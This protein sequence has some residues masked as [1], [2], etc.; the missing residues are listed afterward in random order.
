MK[1]TSPRTKRL[2]LLS[3]TLATL[4]LQA[5]RW[6]DSLYKRYVGDRGYIEPCKGM[7][8]IDAT[9]SKENCNGDGLQWI[10]PS[11]VIDG[12]V[13]GGIANESD[14]HGT[15]NP[16]KCKYT[17]K[18]TCPQEHWAEFK[19]YDLGT[20][21]YLMIEKDN[22]YCGTYNDLMSTADDNEDN[23]RK[24]NL[25]ET[26]I[27]QIIEDIDY[28][29]CNTDTSCRTME[30]KNENVA[31][32]TNCSNNEIRCNEDC[33]DIKSSRNNC[34]TCG[35]VCY[36]G[37]LCSDGICTP[38]VQ[39]RQCDSTNKNIYSCYQI[40]GSD[41]LISADDYANDHS[42]PSNDYVITNPDD[43][44]CIS[45]FDETTCGAT[46]CNQESFTP[47]ADGYICIK[48]DDNNYICKCP[49]GTIEITDPVKGNQ[50][51][52]PNDDEHCGASQS[53]PNGENCNTAGEHRKCNGIKCVC[54][55]GWVECNGR[56]IDPLNDNVYCG[57]DAL[58]TQ[59]DECNSQQTCQRGVCVCNDER[60]INCD[61]V[62]ID[63]KNSKPHCGSSGL[64]KSDDRNSKN[65]KGIDCGSAKCIVDDSGPKCECSDEDFYFDTINKECVSK[66]SSE[67]CGDDFIDCRAKYH[68]NAK[69]NSK[70]VCV[71]PEPFVRLDDDKYI[72]KYIEKQTKEGIAASSSLCVDI[73]FD[74]RFCGENL[75]TCN[76]NQM[77]SGGKCKNID[78]TVCKSDGSGKTMLCDNRCINLDENN[79]SNCNKC[80]E[81]W[82]STELLVKTAGCNTQIGKGLNNCAQCL[83]NDN[84]LKGSKCN[85]MYSV[86]KDNKCLCA[87]GETE[88]TVKD[89]DG[90]NL[91][92]DMSKINLE[93]CSGIDCPNGFRCKD[94]W[95]DCIDGENKTQTSGVR[96]G[97]VGIDG[98]ETNIHEGQIMDNA[99]NNCGAC[100]NVCS[101]ENVNAA[102]CMDGICDY[103]ECKKVKDEK[104]NEIKD[105]EGN[106]IRYANCSGNRAEGCLT[107]LSND[108][109][110]CGVCGKI[111]YE[112]DCDKGKCCWNNKKYSTDE[113]NK[114]DC[115]LGT[116]LYQ[117]CD[118][119]IFHRTR[120][121]CASSK[122][123]I[124]TNGWCTWTLVE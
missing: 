90:G 71:C 12:V 70:G 61:G 7:C 36:D 65:F 24:C 57:A 124:D 44:I 9:F 31:V 62:C 117:A 95:G 75:E 39:L 74:N 13:N 109:N 87:S 27:K 119:N 4:G 49:A 96:E 101:P 1:N 56:C 19:L 67:S 113:L 17:T 99:I 48:D 45:P 37:E 59:W 106:E 69:C 84:M 64:C 2:L 77:C 89:G 53:N 18:D 72:E 80:K 33:V 91:C 54:E 122:P 78:A 3:A 66:N 25:S 23:K 63:P 121:T 15:W 114:E 86:C 82:C 43:P 107:D 76:D 58:C 5:C 29:L 81:G 97:K 103:D 92:V 120:Y 46:G 47:C 35:N 6:D 20:G 22:Y 40:E 102:I 98:C 68:P 100:G 111:C 60:S 123:T 105:E 51:V 112:G 83:Y 16:G 55:P 11:C 85:D 73:Q 28:G 8:T 26:S 10:E 118:K 42:D 108:E 110:N 116:N 32:C 115:C 104:G 50:C 79:M 30:F 41:K 14:C 38:I 88:L 94:G 52:N 21:Q 93:H 34:G